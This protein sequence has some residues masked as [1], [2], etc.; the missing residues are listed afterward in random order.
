[1]ANVN[2]LTRKLHWRVCEYIHIYIYIYSL[3][4][5][6]YSFTIQKI[7]YA[8]LAVLVLFFLFFHN[9]FCSVANIYILNYLTNDAKNVI[10]FT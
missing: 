6:P 10:N 9:L 1:M 7:V 3:L 8:A 4:V 5:V 2:D